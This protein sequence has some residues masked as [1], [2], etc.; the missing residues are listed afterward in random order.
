MLCHLSYILHR[1]VLKTLDTRLHNSLLMVPR[2]FSD[3]LKHN[4]EFPSR[5]K[6]AFYVTLLILLAP[7]LRFVPSR[8]QSTHFVTQAFASCFHHSTCFPSRIH[9]HINC[10]TRAHLLLLRIS[11]VRLCASQSIREYCQS[12]FISFQTLSQP[13]SWVQLPSGAWHFTEINSLEI[14]IYNFISLLLI[15]IKSLYVLF[16]SRYLHFLICYALIILQNVQCAMAL[17]LTPT[18]A[19]MRSKPNVQVCWVCR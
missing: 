4:L 9:S 13:E 11:P 12:K 19:S 16:V 10:C 15:E 3:L 14:V 2:S 5:H 1:C 7:Y 18:N 17:C 8:L 6:W